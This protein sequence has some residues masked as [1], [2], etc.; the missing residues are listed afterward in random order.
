MK[1]SNEYIDL[2]NKKLEELKNID[3]W[4]TK[5]INTEHNDIIN[6]FGLGLFK[7]E[8]I[9]FFKECFDNKKCKCGSKVKE[10][11]YGID[12]T[13]GILIKDALKKSYSDIT[14]ETTLKNILVAY[15]EEHREC[16]ITFQCRKC[17]LKEEI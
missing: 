12:K 14:E 13:R 9:S 3:R 15:F 16:D 17:Y 2:I 7:L 5:V 8:T 6:D 1:D 10:I 11:F 4:R